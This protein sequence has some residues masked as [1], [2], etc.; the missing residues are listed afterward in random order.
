MFAAVLAAG[1]AGVDG[2][3]PLPASVD[4]PIDELTADELAARELVQ[5]PSSLGEAIERFAASELMRETLGESVAESL[6]ANKRIEWAEYRRQVTPFE[7]DRYLP[8]L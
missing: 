4:R 3:Y 1:L 6:V 7:I 5:L 2:D 8:M